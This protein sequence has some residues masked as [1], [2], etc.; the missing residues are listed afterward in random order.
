[1]KFF[2]RILRIPLSAHRSLR[3]VTNRLNVPT[4]LNVGC[5]RGC[6]WHTDCRI[7]TAWFS[8]TSR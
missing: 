2:A 8:K 3:K 6:S 7:R 5:N 4:S 1:M